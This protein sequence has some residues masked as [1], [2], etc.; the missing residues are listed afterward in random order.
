MADL[1]KV[2]DV[3][4]SALQAQSVRLNTV[5]SNLANA[6]TVSG[7]PEDVYRSKH[8]IFATVLEGFGRDSSAASVRVAGILTTQA[9][10]VAEHAPN[11]PLADEL[12]FIYRPNISVVEQMADMISA[13][14]SYQT[15]VEVMT[16][17]R[18][19]LLRTLQLGQQ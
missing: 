14:R 9:D 7:Q 3:S 17:S 12:G 19:L 16:T 2:F 10:P 6:Q 11:H 15:N 8:P 18:T 1:F 4:A 5:A 13:S